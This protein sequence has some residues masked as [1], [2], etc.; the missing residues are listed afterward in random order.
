[1]ISNLQKVIF[2]PFF[3]RAGRTDRAFS[4]PGLGLLESNFL[5]PIPTLNYL[6]MSY[7]KDY[8]ILRSPGTIGPEG[9]K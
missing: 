7:L 1:M 5:L 9:A 8:L 2:E 4:H 6:N 3:D